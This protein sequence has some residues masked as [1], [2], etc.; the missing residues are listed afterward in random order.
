M[1]KGDQNMQ[2]TLSPNMVR[3][4]FEELGKLVT[5][6][7]C[8]HADRDQLLALTGALTTVPA[9]RLPKKRRRRRPK[10]RVVS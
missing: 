2:E 7:D 8:T 4:F 9:K 5:D 1:T 3:R 10:L 6:T